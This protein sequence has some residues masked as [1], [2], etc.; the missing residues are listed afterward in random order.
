MFTLHRL[1]VF[2]INLT[3][4]YLSFYI[5]LVLNLTLANLQ[6]AQQ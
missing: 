3:Y 6:L 2:Y 5:E 1:R 4:D